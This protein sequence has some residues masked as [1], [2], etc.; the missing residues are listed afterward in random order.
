M[1]GSNTLNTNV[2][3][4]A[5]LFHVQTELYSSS[6]KIVTIIFLKGETFLRIEHT[7][8]ESPDTEIKDIHK[9]IVNRLSLLINHSITREKI[10]ELLIKTTGLENVKFIEECFQLKKENNELK[11]FSK[12][13]LSGLPVPPGVAVFERAC[14]DEIDIAAKKIKI[15]KTAPI[16]IKELETDSGARIVENLHKLKENLKEIKKPFIIL[17][18]KALCK[19]KSS[20]FILTFDPLSEEKVVIIEST[21][22]IGG[23]LNTP[24]QYLDK[25]RVDRETFEFWRIKKEI[26]KK[27]LKLTI[28]KGNIFT[29]TVADERELT[30]SLS[31]EEILKL[32]KLALSLEKNFSKPIKIAFLITEEDEI[33][34]LTASTI[35]PKEKREILRKVSS[36]E[37]PFSY[38]TGTKIL[39]EIGTVEEGK[40]CN[41]IP[42]SGVLI[43]AENFSLLEFNP[44]LLYIAELIFPKLVIVNSNK[45][46]FVSVIKSAREKGFTNIYIASSLKD[47]PPDIPYFKEVESPFI[48]GK[49]FKGTLGKLFTG[50]KDTLSSNL[51]LVRELISSGFDFI[52]APAD[53]I[54]TLKK[55]IASEEKALLLKMARKFLLLKERI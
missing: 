37:E 5:G 13:Y 15:D 23:I 6:N 38:P 43:K 2:K 4:P 19:T 8:G 18:G 32:T 45:K 1:E 27:Q 21:L 54:N 11:Q 12:L 55:L 28:R 10:K 47:I 14:W 48:A 30:S 22:G 40:L 52:S 26:I 17:N 33:L 3:T 49:T 7:P 36:L 53:E 34:F 50:Y 31:D 44:L 24:K 41:L 16:I 29:E 51:S 42:S 9:S 46:D 35:T 39:I 20:G 25:F